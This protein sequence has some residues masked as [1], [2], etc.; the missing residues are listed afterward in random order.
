MAWN[1]YTPFLGDDPNATDYVATKSLQSLENAIRSLPR[2]KSV[3]QLERPT[4]EEL[5]GKYFVSKQ[6][7]NANVNKKANALPKQPQQPQP[8]QANPEDKERQAA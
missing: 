2:L 4:R 3:Q 6:N 5:I 1:Q 8:N 7:Y